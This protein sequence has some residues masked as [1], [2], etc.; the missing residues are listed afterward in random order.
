MSCSPCQ[1]LPGTTS[2]I[3]VPGI[4]GRGVCN[5]VNLSQAKCCGAPLNPLTGYDVDNPPARTFPNTAWN[6]ASPP[7]SLLP[8][9]PA[10]A[11]SLYL[12]IAPTLT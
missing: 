6:P 5:P 9:P 2:V 1:S 3:L 4:G 8:N 11:I 10:F 12:T 7:P